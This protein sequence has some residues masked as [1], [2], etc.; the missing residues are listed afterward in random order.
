MSHSRYSQRRNSADVALHGSLLPEHDGILL[1][2]LSDGN[3]VD[4]C[5][6]CYT[7]DSGEFLIIY[8]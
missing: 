4:H 5:G 3:R 6:W 2:T 1:I 7:R 8:R